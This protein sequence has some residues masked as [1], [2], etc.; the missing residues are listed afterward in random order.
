MP[1]LFIS[2]A[3]GDSRD[4]VAR[5]SAALEERGQDTWVDLEDIPP[6]SSWNE[7]LRAGI[8]AS[9][10]FCFVIS[11]ASVGSPHCRAELDHAVALGKRI[12]PVICRSLE[13]VSPRGV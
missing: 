11:P 9:D 4:F 3:R 5:L 6:A 10:S 13:D 8:A 1:D 7:D 2:Y 12:L